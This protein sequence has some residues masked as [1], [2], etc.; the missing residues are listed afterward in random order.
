M[1]TQTIL[2]ETSFDPSVAY[3]DLYT[4]QLRIESTWKQLA[5]EKLTAHLTL[6]AQIGKA[7]TLSTGKGLI[8]FSW[9]TVL[10]NVKAFLE[11][12]LGHKRGVRPGY[13]SI[14]QQ[15]Q[16]VFPDEQRAATLLAF[17][18]FSTLLNKMFMHEYRLT[19]LSAAVGHAIE[20]EVRL[21]AYIQAHPEHAGMTIQGMAQR[22]QEFYKEYYAGRRMAH[23]GFTWNGWQT[24]Q[25]VHLGAK[26]IELV[27]QGSGYFEIV[28][29]K[30]PKGNHVTEVHPTQWLLDTWLKNEENIISKASS[31]CPMVIPPAPWKD[32]TSGGYY[33]DL[34]VHSTLLRVVT[35]DGGQENGFVRKYIDQLRQVDLSRVEA[36]I[37]A[38]QET[39]WVINK[40]VLA[41][42]QA[43][44]KR[45][46]ELAGLPR[47]EPLPEVHRLV[48]DFTE[49]ELKAN[50]DKAVQRIK[51]ETKRK[52][53]A[54]RTLT[55]LRT[56]EEFQKYERIYFPH[57]MDFRGRVYPIPSF[58]PQGDDLNRAL[59]LFADAPECQTTEDI[60]W[61]MVQGANC[62]G[63]DK[64][65]YADRRKWVLDNEQHILAS[66]EDPLGYLWWSKVAEKDYPFQFLAFCFEWKRWKEYEATYGT[67]K[68]FQT[69]L[70]VAFDG[71][72]SG[73]QHFSAI[74]R[75]PVGGQAVNLIPAEKP[76][77]I[78]G[79]VASKVNVILQ[80]DAIEGT[81]D[82]EK[83]SQKTGKPYIKY[84][85]K[86]LAQQW[87]SYGVDRK[88]TKRSVMTLAYGSK[89]YGFR[90][91]LLE[92]IIEPALDEGR[93]SMF[94]DKNQSAAYLA[95]LI[96]QVVQKVVIKAV[97]GMK[98]LQQVARMV[99]KQGRVVAWTTPMGLPVQQSYMEYNVEE[100]R[101]R[102]LGSKRYIHIGK[103]TG[104]I[105]K[106]HQASGIAPNFI[107]SMD[108]AHLQK[109]V[110]MAKEAGI[111]HFTMIH[112]SYGSPV[113]QAG[114]MYKTVRQAFI[115]MYTET[116][117]L[118]DF[119]TEMSVYL[120]DPKEIPEV[121]Y[122]GKLDLN[123][124]EN[125]EYIFS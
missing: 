25:R 105:N 93:G 21:E 66:A 91:Q 5:E 114:R 7:A 72:C 3:G 8:D 49:E 2:K 61:L 96:W 97:E 24:E 34:K 22:V 108:A 98:W 53:K 79:I 16:E 28:N 92:D 44:I 32:F 120:D 1:T 124:I 71:T 94:I 54:L 46:G 95:K 20:A 51:L 102:F 65:S 30:G 75:D 90:E 78:Y 57:N 19:N 70:Y 6:Q 38:I 60:G 41:V 122:K 101:L 13:Y 63:V 26:L 116:D 88:V 69:G 10:E 18:A 67:P 11:H 115:N 110:V 117:V 77:D 118:Q 58:S 55:V 112:D 43:I 29:G 74:L 56:A 4:K 121:P 17:S 68:G 86:S 99:C 123:L 62:A 27:M 12:T 40:E 42:A 52:S 39:P 59:L 47:T 15:V 76:Q 111:N 64:V 109:T 125:S 14:L 50:K 103:P 36:A 82:E 37:N 81:L 85:T 100:F 35:R 104:N 106:L 23:A 84:G 48:G 33:G 80:K 87:L 31:S 89:E 83:V 73:L 9:P 113:A 119:Q 107:H 45:G